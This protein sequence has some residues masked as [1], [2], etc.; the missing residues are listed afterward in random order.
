[1]HTWARA[2]PRPCHG[3]WFPG[4]APSPPRFVGWR[5]SASRPPPT[6][7]AP[8]PSRGRP[9]CQPA[10]EGGRGRWK[11]NK[12]RTSG[13]GETCTPSPR[14]SVLSAPQFPSPA[15][16]S[17]PRPAPS[18]LKDLPLDVPAVQPSR[19]LLWRN[20]SPPR[21]SA[22]PSASLPA[23]PACA[24]PPPESAGTGSGQATAHRPRARAWPPWGDPHILTSSLSA[25]VFRLRS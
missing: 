13:A 15:R 8:R 4:L 7:P 18:P 20:C 1:M 19:P 24:W 6:K 5:L 14:V 10:A 22:K 16:G 23:S 9:G 25:A 2:E 17:A 21:L 11:E 3:M 12:A